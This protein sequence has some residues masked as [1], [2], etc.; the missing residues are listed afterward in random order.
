MHLLTKNLR[1]T[2]LILGLMILQLMEHYVVLNHGKMNSFP[3]SNVVGE[4]L[5]LTIVIPYIVL[6][7]TT[8]GNYKAKLA[9]PI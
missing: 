6:I 4:N 8:N 2:Y 5:M 7:Q 1:S 3:F 9:T